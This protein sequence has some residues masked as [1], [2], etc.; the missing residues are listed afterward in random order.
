MGEHDDG[1]TVLRAEIEAFRQGFGQPDL[2]TA[3]LRAAVVLLPV[4]DDDRI[5]ISTVR[6]VDWVCAFT[7]EA[8][9]TAYLHARREA[10]SVRY[11]ALFGRRLLDEIVPAL[12][13]PT[14]VVIDAAGAAPMAF[15]PDLERVAS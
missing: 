8:E 10:A 5:L 3:A 12:P 1:R 11:R 7:D 14:G 4:T 9:Y 13:R 15:P 6:G 2:L